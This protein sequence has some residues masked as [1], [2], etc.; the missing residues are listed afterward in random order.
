MSWSRSGKPD[1]D[2]EGMEFLF[3]QKDGSASFG[4]K[5]VLSL[6]GVDPVVWTQLLDPL[7]EQS[8]QISYMI[9]LLNSNIV[10]TLYWQSSFAVIYERKKVFEICR[11]K[12]LIKLNVFIK[13]PYASMFSTE[14]KI[15]QIAFVGMVK[16]L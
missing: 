2:L 1:P 10:V 4:A 6:N 5:M 7:V 13:E 8:A 3:H 14:E 12:N 9:L 15:T 11:R 16:N